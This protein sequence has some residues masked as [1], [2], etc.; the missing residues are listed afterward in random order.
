MDRR[1][2]SRGRLDG[3]NALEYNGTVRFTR[4]N[5]RSPHE[6]GSAPSAQYSVLRARIDPEI[7]RMCSS[8][9]H[10]KPSTTLSTSKARDIIQQ[11]H[12]CVDDRRKYNDWRLRDRTTCVMIK[13]CRRQV[14]NPNIDQTRITQ[15]TRSAPYVRA[16]RNLGHFTPTYLSRC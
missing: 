4:K 8:T 9:Q 1:C 7:P 16:G 15:S 10:D 11:D 13:E 6:Q 5:A 3:L 12:I 14:D 2:H